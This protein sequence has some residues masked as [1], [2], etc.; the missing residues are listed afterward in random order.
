MAHDIRNPLSAVTVTLGFLSL[1]LAR[2]GD[3]RVGEALLAMRNSLEHVDCIISDLLELAQAGAQPSPG[4]VAEVSA[5]LDRVVANVRAGATTAGIELSIEQAPEPTALLAVACSTGILSILFDNLISN[6][7]KYMGEAETR[8]IKIRVLPRG[9]W[10]RCEVEDTGPGIPADQAQKIF[11]P[12]VR[13]PGAT[14]TGIGLGLATVR[15]AVQAHGGRYG[16]TSRVGQGAQFWFE[17]P[18]API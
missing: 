16:V 9:A 14:G 4:A 18:R 10:V 7:I 2:A 1:L 11:E 15:R 5:V 3:K 12:F 6:A 17:L 13:G 8:R